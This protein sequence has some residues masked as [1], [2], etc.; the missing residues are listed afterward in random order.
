[1]QSHRDGGGVTCP[2]CRG[3]DD[4]SWETSCSS[5]GRVC[6]SGFSRERRGWRP[7]PQ[8]C[9]WQRRSR[10]VCPWAHSGS[11]FLTLLLLS[12][13]WKFLA[14]IF[15]SCPR[16]PCRIQCTDSRN[17]GSRR[18]SWRAGGGRLECGSAG[19][20]VACVRRGAGGWQFGG[21][22]AAVSGKVSSHRNIPHMVPYPRVQPSGCVSKLA[23]A[24]FPWSSGSEFADLVFA[25]TIKHNHSR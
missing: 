24:R 17:G 1:M 12:P 5:M 16:S 8:Q 2:P 4:F 6:L 15:D 22:G 3:S 14:P 18:R 23:G 21:Q 11:L 10:A 13:P 9:C 19:A 20:G 25:M 7:H